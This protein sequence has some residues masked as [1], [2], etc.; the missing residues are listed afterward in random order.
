MRGF[1]QQFGG[2][3]PGGKGPPAKKSATTSVK[4]EFEGTFYNCDVPL[5]TFFDDVNDLIAQKIG[6]DVDA[7]SFQ[8][9]S[10]DGD[11]VELD[12]ATE[13]D[14]NR[15]KLEMKAFREDSAEESEMSASEGEGEEDDTSRNDDAIQTVEDLASAAVSEGKVE[16]GGAMSAQEA[17]AFVIEQAKTHEDVRTF[18]LNT[19]GGFD[20]LVQSLQFTFTYEISLENQSN[21]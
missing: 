1:A 8:I 5:A 21:K 12:D 17:R 2:G 9:R 15:P 10:K 13:E 3:K 18:I 7:L 19:V 4:C 11:W 16:K 14:K 20:H 6:E